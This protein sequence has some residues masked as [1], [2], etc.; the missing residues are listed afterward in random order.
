VSALISALLSQRLHHLLLVLLVLWLL[1]VASAVL[2]TPWLRIDLV[3]QLL[4]GRLDR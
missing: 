2:R 4:P 3:L 1:G